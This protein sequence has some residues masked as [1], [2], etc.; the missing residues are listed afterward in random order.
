MET[1]FM[2]TENSKTNEPHKF[3]LNLSQR[4]DLRSA[5]KHVVLQN[6]SIYYTWKNIRKQYKNNKSK[7]IAPTWNDEF[8]LSDRSYSVLD[9]QDYIEYIIKKHETLTTIPPIHFYTNR[10]NNRLVFKI[11]D[12]Y[13]LELETP[14]TMKLFG[15]IKK[16]IG[17]TKN[18]E[19]VPSLE[20][21]EVVLVRCN[22][23]DNQYQ[24]KSEVLFTF[25]LNKSYAY[26]ST[27]EP[28][29]L[30]FWKLITQSL[31]KLL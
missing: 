7:I 23:V 4:L 2:N 12:G 17:K 25:T 8:E 18:G 27:V 20:V 16:L 6:L 22:L 13:K 10:I 5:D 9:I 1:I 19:N 28:S 29:D 11:K 15:S 21:A 3:V 26:L 31:M 30:V 24:Q 14:E